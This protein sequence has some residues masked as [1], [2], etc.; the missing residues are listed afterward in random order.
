MW[1]LGAA[2]LTVVE[3]VV[4]LVGC[5]LEKLGRAAVRD[6]ADSLRELIVANNTRPLSLDLD[7]A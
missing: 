7:R 3:A 1:F 6:I 5:S 4:V 2:R